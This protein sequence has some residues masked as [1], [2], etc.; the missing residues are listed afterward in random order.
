MSKKGI[1]NEEFKNKKT[2][3]SV[4]FGNKCNFVGHE[5]FSGC[6]SLEKVIIPPTISSIDDRAFGY[7][8]SLK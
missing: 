7:C 8:S 6:T 5:A 3:T 1:P 4:K 2:I